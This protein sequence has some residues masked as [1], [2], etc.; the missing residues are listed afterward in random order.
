MAGLSNYKHICIR[1]KPLRPS[2]FGLRDRSALAGHGVTG[3]QTVPPPGGRAA[4]GPAGPLPGWRTMTAEHRSG[5]ARRG[6]SPAPPRAYLLPRNSLATGDPV[7]V[8]PERLHGA[9]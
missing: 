2:W 6:I 4:G 1:V 3:P 8:L 7:A 5:P 9:P